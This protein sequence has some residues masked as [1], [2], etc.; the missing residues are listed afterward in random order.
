MAP[1]MPCGKKAASL[2]AAII[3]ILAGL[4]SWAEFWEAPATIA[5]GRFPSFF[6]SKA[7]PVLI[8]QESQASGESGTARIRFARFEDG[9]WKTGD[10][11]AS[12]YSYNSAGAPPI[13]YSA[14]QARNGTIAVAIA[15]SGTSIEIRLSRDEG[16]SFELAGRLEAG[17]TS[18]APRIYPGASGGWIVF[19]TQGR[20]SSG[21]PAAGPGPGV[22]GPDASA[23][24]GA[25]AASL[26]S[27]VS[28]Y[29]AR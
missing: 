6:P 10:V 16:R 24:A 12:S 2:A 13:L 7:G 9:S 14:T 22:S 5:E 1:I 29:V 21:A 23:A 27:S 19:A 28:I 17:T 18:V 8:W 26:T 4:P 15:A 25:P 3:F 11:S 20:P